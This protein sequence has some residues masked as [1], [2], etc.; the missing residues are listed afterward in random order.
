MEENENNTKT[1]TSEQVTEAKPQPVASN[2]PEVGFPVSSKIKPKSKSGKLVF[3]ILGVVIL[4]GGIIFF[5]SRGKDESEDLVSPTPGFDNLETFT[6]TPIETAE[7]INKEEVSIQ[8]LNGSGISGEAGYLQ[9]QLK[10]LGYDDIEVGNADDQDQ[11]VTTVTFSKELDSA[12]ISVI[13][14]KLEA[15]YK[16]VDV[17]T[18]STQKSDA[19]IITGLRKGATPK[20]SETPTASPTATPTTTATPT[21]TPTESPT[22]TPTPT[23]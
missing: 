10:T 3:I 5:V 19:V 12:N 22:P 9:G 15:I 8:V 11:E 16:E 17:K 23:S 6:P 21:E 18:S 7:P 2:N 4:I 13:T 20:P 14:D 1:E